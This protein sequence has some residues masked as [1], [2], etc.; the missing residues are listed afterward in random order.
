MSVQSSKLAG[1]RA[2]SSYI[3]KLSWSS[4]RYVKGEKMP[5]KWRK[6][7]NYH[8][9]LP[10]G[11]CMMMMTYGL[12]SSDPLVWEDPCFMKKQKQKR[13]REERETKKKKGKERKRERGRRCKDRPNM[14]TVHMRIQYV[15]A[16]KIHRCWLDPSIPIFSLRPDPIPPGFTGPTPGVRGIN[17]TWE[18]CKY[19]NSN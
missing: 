9:Y 1:R 5:S 11:L 13:R 12:V 4:V 15:G 17:H 16:Y 19:G 10:L 18:H 8:W 7:N 2:Y 6:D 3:L 14:I